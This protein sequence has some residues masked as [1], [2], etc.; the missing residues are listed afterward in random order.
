T[1]IL[2]T[3]KSLNIDTD[4]IFGPNYNFFIEIYKFK[5]IVN[6]KNWLCNICTRIMDHISVERQDT[7]DLIVARAKEYIRLNYHCSDISIN[8]VCSYLHISPSYFSSIFKK[9]TKETFISYLAKCRMEAA[10]ELLRITDMKTFE[11]A[12]KVGYA[13]PNY[14]SYCFK[15]HFGMSPTEYRN[16]G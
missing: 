15:K 9:K 4:N 7:C 14:F 3:A 12:K 2:K 11:I 8:K 13:E 1:S 16:N 5:N 6:V 10:K